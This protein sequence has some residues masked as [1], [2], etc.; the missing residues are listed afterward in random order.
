MIYVHFLSSRYPTFVSL[1]IC[2]S[3]WYAANFAFNK[4]APPQ[5]HEEKK[6]ATSHY[7]CN[8]GVADSN[9]LLGLC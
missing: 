7:Y 9:R 3:P 5:F 2:I 8:Y 1:M 4:M 6:L